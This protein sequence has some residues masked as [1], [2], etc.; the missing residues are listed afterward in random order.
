MTVHR[1]FN[2]TLPIALGIFLTA[3][4]ALANHHEEQQTG[5]VDL[6]KI[7]QHKAMHKEKRA[8]MHD[9]KGQH[10]AMRMHDRLDTN[11]DDKVDLNEFLSHAEGRFH[12]MDTDSDQ[13]VTDEEAKQHHKN[14]RKKHKGMKKKHKQHT[15]D[16]VDK[17][18]DK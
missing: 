6:E 7:E 10:S 14:M 17:E 18:A 11:E 2:K 13:F 8:K 9:R 16:E 3:N 15:K 12:E 4:V 5:E 1:Y